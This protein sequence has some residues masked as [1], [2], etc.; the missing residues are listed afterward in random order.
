M[1]EFL[2]KPIICAPKLSRLQC[3]LF[4]RNMYMIN[5]NT[6]KYKVFVTIKVP[7]KSGAHKSVAH[8][9]PAIHIA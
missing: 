1:G 9:R 6:E 5:I 4:C 3:K 8:G 2:N 7:S